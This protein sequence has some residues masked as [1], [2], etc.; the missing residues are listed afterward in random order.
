MKKVVSFLA[1]PRTAPR[2][3]VIERLRSESMRGESRTTGQHS[4]E[5]T[6]GTGRVWIGPRGSFEL[7]DYRRAGLGAIGYKNQRL[8]KF[9]SCKHARPS[10]RIAVNPSVGNLQPK[11]LDREG[12]RYFRTNK[13]P[14]STFGHIYFPSSSRNSV[15]AEG[16]AA[17][18]A[19]KTIPSRS[20]SVLAFNM[21]GNGSVS[22]AGG[23]AS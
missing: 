10:N 14:V 1:E 13:L 16:D 12:A 4:Q 18:R 15:A 11:S 6:F 20:I 21:N 7:W 2:T 22:A 23:R 19:G 5:M 8:R 17:S 3:K 9:I